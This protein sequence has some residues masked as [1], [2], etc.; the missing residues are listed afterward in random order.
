MA[1][2]CKNFLSNLLHCLRYFLELT[3]ERGT[4]TSRGDKPKNGFDIVMP[5]FDIEFSKSRYNRAL[6]PAGSA[7]VC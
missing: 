3:V 4:H 6:A 1:A 7:I 5:F 2:A